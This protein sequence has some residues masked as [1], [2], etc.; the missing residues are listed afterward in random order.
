MFEKRLTSP[1]ITIDPRALHRKA[2]LAHFNRQLA[3]VASFPIFS[4]ASKLVELSIQI[5]EHPRRRRQSRSLADA[6]GLIRRRRRRRRRRR[7]CGCVAFGQDIPRNNI[8]RTTPTINLG[9]DPR[10]RNSSASLCKRHTATLLPR[11]TVATWVVA[12]ARWVRPTT[13]KC[14]GDRGGPKA[15]A[16]GG[17]ERRPE[18]Q[19]NHQRR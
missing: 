11:V 19:R 8:A 7:Q 16:A 12:S 2:L 4:F 14:R 9:R 13:W 3:T 1:T 15:T 17:R 6:S 5:E 10:A 18:W